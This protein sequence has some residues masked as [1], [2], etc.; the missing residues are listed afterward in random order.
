MIFV[1]VGTS[2]YFPGFPRLVAWMDDWA[3]RHPDEEVVI[4]MSNNPEPAPHAARTFDQAPLAEIEA[5][6][7]QARWT[8]S[9]AGAGSILTCR[10]LRAPTIIVPRLAEHGEALDDHQLDLA[11]LLGEQGRI[12]V[13]YDQESL[14]R[15]L[16]TDPA[17][18]PEPPEAPLVAHLRDRITEIARPDA[19]R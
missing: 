3:R 8:V 4:Q 7:R 6:T 19:D 16:A 11:R 10:A 13:A 1:T 14:E 18:I 2:T 5:L 17:A 9:H 15:L 12:H